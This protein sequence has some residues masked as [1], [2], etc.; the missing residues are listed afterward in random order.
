LWLGRPAGETFGGNYGAASPGLPY[1]FQEDG[2]ASVSITPDTSTGPANHLSSFTMA[3]AIK[4]LVLH[5]EEP[6]QQLPGIQWDDV[7]TLLHGAEGSTKYGDWGGM[8]ADTTVYF[9]TGHDIDYIERRSQGRWRIFSKLGL[10]SSG[11]FLD[12]GYACLPVL[13]DQLQPVPG[14]GREMVIASALP[15]G[16]SSWT[17]RDR[18]LAQ[19][20]RSIMLRVVDG[21]L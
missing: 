9:Q 15:T 13:D 2:G 5:R 6:A 8:S 11:Q 17:E 19:A 12:V 1:T 20:F 14:W 4:R 21:R 10:G 18:M 7:S 3:E 16:G